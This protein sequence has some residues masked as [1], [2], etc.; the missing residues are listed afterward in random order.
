MEVDIQTGQPKPQVQADAQ[1]AAERQQTKI[2]KDE[3]SFMSV[4]ESRARKRL[5][6]EMEKILIERVKHFL[7][8][9]PAGQVC[10]RLMSHIDSKH[11]LARIAVKE[12]MTSRQD[13]T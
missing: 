11:N 6:A 13:N 2:L 9:D 5:T 4:S 8:Q 10:L 1:R 3:A 12:L 7:D